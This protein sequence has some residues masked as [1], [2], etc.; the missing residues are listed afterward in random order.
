MK[1]FPL[2]NSEKEKESVAECPKSIYSTCPS[3]H[4][5]C[6]FFAGLKQAMLGK[7]CIIEAKDHKISEDEKWKISKIELKECQHDFPRQ[8][9]NSVRL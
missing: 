3:K 5:T 7:F 8:D 6:L 1:R 9:K 4:G 2:I